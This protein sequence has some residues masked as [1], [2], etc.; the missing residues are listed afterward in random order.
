MNGQAGSPTP[1][2]KRRRTDFPRQRL[3]EAM[4]SLVDVP[5]PRNAKYIAILALVSGVILIM[6]ALLRPRQATSTQAPIPSESEIAQLTRRAERRTLEDTSNFF[7]TTAGEV[8]QFV[9]RLPDMGT[10]GIAWND[11]LVVAPPSPAATPANVTVRAGTQNRRARTVLRGP[12]LPLV[13]IEVAETEPA[14]SPARRAPGEPQPGSWFVAVWRASSS[15]AFGAGQVLQRGTSACGVP[16]VEELA[17]SLPLTRAMAGGGLF[18]AD[19]GLLGAILPCGDRFAAVA[20]SSIEALLQ[21][22]G[23]LDQELV[24]RYG[25]AFAAMT[26]EEMAHFKSSP[27]VIVREVW[28]GYPGDEAGLIPGDIVT[29]VNGKLVENAEDLRV[30]TDRADADT[31]ELTLRRGART[32]KRAL[33][34][35]EAPLRRAA[36]G[37][38]GVVLET[39]RTGYAIRSILP[40]SVAARAGI[41]AGDR[42]IRIDRVE[43]R[44]AARVDRLLAAAR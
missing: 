30:L 44:S 19:G 4:A 43:P 7:S 26:A 32:L 31:F 17:L 8:E 14:V 36:A 6:G 33:P 29:A 2:C 1:K 11:R 25:V 41:E 18:D 35:G 20:S 3:R 5:Q 9:V 15:R 24:S 42:V 21:R 27:G 39:P 12:Q 37:A 38:A 23:A 28:T 34:A 16:M 22:A 10:S 13:A 40:G